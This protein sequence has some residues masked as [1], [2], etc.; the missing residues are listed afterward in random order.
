MR[1]LILF[2]DREKYNLLTKSLHLLLISVYNNYNVLMKKIL[3]HCNWF[4]PFA[5]VRVIIE[6]RVATH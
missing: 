4:E 1:D 3:Q 2:F 6:I 5:V